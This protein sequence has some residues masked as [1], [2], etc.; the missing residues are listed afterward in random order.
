MPNSAG[1]PQPSATTTR[2]QAVRRTSRR[3]SGPGRAWKMPCDGRG[4][5]RPSRGAHSRRA[6]YPPPCCSYSTRRSCPPASSASTR[7]SVCMSA[8]GAA[9][10][11]QLA[12]EPDVEPVVARAVQFDLTRFGE[13]PEAPPAH[14]EEAPRQ[15]RV[16]GEEVEIDAGTD[17]VD[18]R[19][20]READVRVHRAVQADELCGPCFRRE[21]ERGQGDDR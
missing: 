4:R 12:V 2:S 18:E 9:P 1:A 16:G 17:V 8:R 14:A 6:A 10:D 15:V 19:R 21:Q 5:G 13:V 7:V 3:S 11:Q 20:A